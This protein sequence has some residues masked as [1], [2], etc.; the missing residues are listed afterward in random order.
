MKALTRNFKIRFIEEVEIDF[1]VNPCSICGENDEIEIIN[2]N[3]RLNTLPY[4]T[5]KRC[6]YTISSTNVRKAIKIWNKLQSNNE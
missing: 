6:N 5:C 4:I 3:N 2:D 1:I